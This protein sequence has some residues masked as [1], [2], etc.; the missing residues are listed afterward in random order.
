MDIVQVCKASKAAGIFKSG[1][2]VECKVLR[3]VLHHMYHLVQLTFSDRGV[4]LRKT[5]CTSPLRDYLL[6]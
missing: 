6:N 4:R 3:R 5:Y 2:H 1:T